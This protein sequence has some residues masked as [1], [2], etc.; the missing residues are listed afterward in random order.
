MVEIQNTYFLGFMFCSEL[1]PVVHMLLFYLCVI[2][3]CLLVRVINNRA[4]L[5]ART[6]LSH[7]G[8]D[9]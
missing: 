4:D 2:E 9:T 7:R 3:S 6:S 8:A 1:F 5:L